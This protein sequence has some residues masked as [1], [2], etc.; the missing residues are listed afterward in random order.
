MNIWCLFLIATTLAVEISPKYVVEFHN[1]KISREKAGTYMSRYG[2]DVVLQRL[3]QADGVLEDGHFEL[4]Q[5]L[6]YT[7]ATCRT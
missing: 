7:C 5:G 6:V 3:E 2:R 4:L 1:A